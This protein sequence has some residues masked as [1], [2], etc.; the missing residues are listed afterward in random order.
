[1]VSN[2]EILTFSQ[3]DKAYIPCKDEIIVMIAT[4]RAF[5]FVEISNTVRIQCNSA[6]VGNS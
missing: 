5:D 1:M 6:L 2:E 4:E 3:T